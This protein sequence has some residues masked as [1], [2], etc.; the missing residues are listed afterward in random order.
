[1]HLIYHVS[2]CI[3]IIFFLRNDMSACSVV[4][5]RVACRYYLDGRRPHLAE[6]RAPPSDLGD[7]RPDLGEPL[8]AIYIYI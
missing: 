4:S 1:M 2:Q 8:S 6:C 7:P 5:C 3:E